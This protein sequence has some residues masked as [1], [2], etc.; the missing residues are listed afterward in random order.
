MEFSEEDKAINFVI[1]YMVEKW[2]SGERR[3]GLQSTLKIYF[4]RNPDKDVLKK[5][6]G[7]VQV[8]LKAFNPPLFILYEN[9]AME[10]THLT[11]EI[12]NKEKKYLTYLEEVKNDRFRDLELKTSTIEYNEESRKID[13]R[14]NFIA[15]LSLIVAL[16]TGAV[17]L[18]YYYCK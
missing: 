5:L 12:Y 1:N 16:V 13:E 6:L 15:F 11:Y 2:E 4:G 7:D 3:I 9:L 8:K 18:I 17:T 10:P 14:A